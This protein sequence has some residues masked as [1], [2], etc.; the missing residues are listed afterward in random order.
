MIRRADW[1]L[2]TKFRDNL[3]V[4]FSRVKQFYS[5]NKIAWPS[6]MGPTGCPRTPVTNYQST[7]RNISEERRSHLHR[8]RSLQSRQWIGQTADGLWPVP[9]PLNLDAVP[10]RLFLRVSRMHQAGWNLMSVTATDNANPLSFES[11]NTFIHNLAS[12]SYN[13]FLSD[14]Q[15]FRKCLYY[16]H[17]LT[18]KIKSRI[19]VILLCVLSTDQSCHTR[20]SI[21]AN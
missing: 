3:S 9:A 6:K 4:L 16:E 21:N 19:K 12:S 8:G 11:R 7:L 13:Y 14:L 17:N 15:L 18:T 20:Q 5:K 10:T 2:L 1:Y